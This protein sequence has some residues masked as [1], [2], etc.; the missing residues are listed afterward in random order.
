MFT[1][2]DPLWY[3]KF[4]YGI[5]H[6]GKNFKT[7]VIDK[8]PSLQYRFGIGGNWKA[9]DL[10]VTSKMD[11]AQKWFDDYWERSPST[12]SYVNRGLFE[13]ELEETIINAYTK[14]IEKWT[15]KLEREFEHDFED[16]LLGFVQGERPKSEG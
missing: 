4:Q 6:T 12:N 9:T 3:F 11:A 1:R 14:L 10:R 2:P 16:K 8:L 5:C 15:E 7:T 13:K